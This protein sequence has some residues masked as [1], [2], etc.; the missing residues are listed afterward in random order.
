MVVVTPDLV[1]YGFVGFAW[2]STDPFKAGPGAILSKDIEIFTAGG[3]THCFVGCYRDG[4]LM[5]FES[6][7]ARNALG[8]LTSGPQWRTLQAIQDEYANGGTVD[9]YPLTAK[10]PLDMDQ[11]E[12][13]AK[14]LCDLRAAGKCPY[15]V[16]HLG[17]DAINVIDILGLQEPLESFLLRTRGLVCSECA[18]RIL[19]PLLGLALAAKAIPDT[20][21]ARGQYL[22]V[23]PA[24]LLAA[25]KLIAKPPLANVFRD[26]MLQMPR[27][28]PS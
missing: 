13:D 5:E 2:G 27:Y 10:F 28:V 1:S 16:W 15:A 4:L 11:F 17:A 18:A 8:Q 24:Q 20:R 25:V 14:Q 7:E 3:P 12:I 26:G 21:M 9:L 19:R 6:T 23:T 22:G